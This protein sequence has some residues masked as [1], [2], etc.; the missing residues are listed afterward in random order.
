MLIQPPPAKRRHK[1]EVNHRPP[2]PIHV[3]IIMDG[4][5]RWA[6][7]RGLSRHAGHRAGTENIRRIIEAFAERDV[8]YLTLYAFSTENWGRPRREVNALLRLIGHVIDRELEALHQNG[9]RLRHIGC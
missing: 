8:K 2:A 4:N 6:A 1:A 9:V 7:E 5:G 3:A